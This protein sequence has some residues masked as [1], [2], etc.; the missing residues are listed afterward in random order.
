MPGE[1]GSTG[2]ADFGAL[3]GPLFTA[4]PVALFNSGFLTRKRDTNAG[5]VPI[6]ASRRHT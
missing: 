5:E 4:E 6:A 1:T 3:Y 2:L